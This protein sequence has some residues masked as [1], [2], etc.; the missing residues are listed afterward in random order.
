VSVVGKFADDYSAQSGLKKPHLGWDQIAELHSSGIVEIQSH[1]F[2]LHGKNG[3]GRNKGEAQ[4]DFQRRLKS[5]LARSKEQLEEKLSFTPTTF[6]YPLGVI[7][8]G[9]REVLEDLGFK[10]S[11]SCYEGMS[12]IKQ[13]DPDTLFRLRRNI[14]RSGQP[15]SGILKKLES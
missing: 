9:S 10:S 1:S 2:D 8:N 7:S 15:L 13:D 12:L 14:R 4:E 3:A 6:T 5:D 11:L